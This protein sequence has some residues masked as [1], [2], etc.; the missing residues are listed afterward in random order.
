MVAQC[1]HQ[2]TMTRTLLN[3]RRVFPVLVPHILKTGLQSDGAAV[4]AAD[5]VGELSAVLVDEVRDAELVSEPFEDPHYLR[6]GPGP[7]ADHSC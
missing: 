3:S 1:E 6:H 5:A 7:F 4:A 2:K